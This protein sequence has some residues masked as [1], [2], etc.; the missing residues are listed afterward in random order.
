MNLRVALFNFYKLLEITGEIKG[1]V[2]I[3][4][5]KY[6]MVAHLLNLKAIYEK[7]DMHQL[8]SKISISVLRYCDLVRLDKLYYDAG[9]AC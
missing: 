6:L 7:K 8:L 5:Y 1:N 2:G 3:E 4:F 9:V